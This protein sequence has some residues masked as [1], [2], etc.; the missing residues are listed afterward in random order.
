MYKRNVLI[1]DMASFPGISEES[2]KETL[3]DLELISKEQ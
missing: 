1:K 3:I 2:V